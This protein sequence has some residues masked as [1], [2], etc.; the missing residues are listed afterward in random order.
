MHDHPDRIGPYKIREVLGQGG[1][2]IV[3]LAEQEQPMHRRVALKVIKLGMDTEEVIARFE[4]E[5]QAL[6][7]MN[8][9]NIARVFDAGTTD[10]GSPYFVMEYVP[11][12]PICEYCDRQRLNT[13]ERL[14]L[15]VLVCQAI[16]SPGHQALQCAG[17]G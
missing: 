15:F 1:M 3:Y 4:S 14:D 6:A 10:R 5:R 11:G 12:I 2:G 8:H 17:V 13:R 7:M 16:Q 9:P